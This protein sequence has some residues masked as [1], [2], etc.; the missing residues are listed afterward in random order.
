MSSLPPPPGWYP[1]PG[2]SGGQRWWDGTTWTEHVHAAAPT[3][4][5]TR[6]RYA[7]KWWHLPLVVG[8]AVASTVVSIVVQFLL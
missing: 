8:L 6:R 4:A 2:A 7:Q 1:D 5:P 3:A